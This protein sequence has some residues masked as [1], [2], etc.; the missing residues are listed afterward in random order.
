[1]PHLKGREKLLRDCRL[2]PANRPNGSPSS[3]CTRA[4]SPETRSRLSSD[5]PSPAPTAL[6]GRCSGHAFRTSQSR[7][8]PSPTAAG[9]AGSSADRSTGSWRSPPSANAVR[10]RWKSPGGGCYRWISCS[11]IPS[12]LGWRPN[13]R[14]SL[15]LCSSGSSHSCCPA[16]STPAMP[17]GGSSISPSGCRLPWGPEAAL[18]VYIDPGMGTRT[19]LDSWREAHRVLWQTLRE[20]GW[21]VEVVAVAWEQELLDRAERVMRSWVG[22]ELTEAAR[23]TSLSPVGGLQRRP[24]NSR[25]LWR[26]Q[27]RPEENQPIEAGSAGAPGPGNDRRIPPL[28]VKAVPSYACATEN[29]GVAHLVAHISGARSW[30]PQRFSERAEP[31]TAVVGALPGKPYWRRGWHGFPASAATKRS[32]AAPRVSTPRR[33]RRTG[34]KKVVRATPPF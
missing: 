10:P 32:E 1:M 25:T 3:A 30:Q 23:E 26:A 7:R 17:M 24:G 4:C 18:F 11:I 12:W 16:G 6:S 2:H 8:R 5:T 21:R 9:F 15:A 20:L 13:R 19:E 31:L 33:A 14:S 22:G 28:G 29:G 27:C 34:G